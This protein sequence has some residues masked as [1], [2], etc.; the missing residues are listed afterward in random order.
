[1]NIEE[2]SREVLLALLFFHLTKQRKV[3]EKNTKNWQPDHL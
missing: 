1:M 2:F 3:D